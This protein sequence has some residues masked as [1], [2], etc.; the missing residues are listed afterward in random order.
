MPPMARCFGVAD[1]A[2]ELHF[3][4]AQEDAYAYSHPTYQQYG[5]GVPVF[6]GILRTHFDAGGKLTAV[7]GVAVPI[8]QLNTTPSLP[9]EEAH[10]IAIR[11]CACRCDCCR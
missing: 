5:G 4:A 6:G 11:C 8:D 7:N 3:V 2:S 10:G 9:V 1:A